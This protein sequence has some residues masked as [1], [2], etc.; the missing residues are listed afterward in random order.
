MSCLTAGYTISCAN[1]PS[2]GGLSRVW[3][4]NRDEVTGITEVPGSGDVT[5]VTMDA[6]EVFYEVG[7]FDETG[8][9]TEAGERTDGSCNFVYTK[10]LTISIPKRNLGLRNFVQQTGACCCG[11]VVIYEDSNGTKWIGGF[12]SSPNRTYKL[13]TAEGVTGAALTDANQETLTFQMRSG[14]KDKVFTGTVPV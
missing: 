2:V 14:E 3:L 1:S 7:F 11:F 12:E 6:T 13:Q 5:A 4:A 10:T 9:Q 8:S